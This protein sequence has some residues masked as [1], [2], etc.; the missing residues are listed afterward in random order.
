MAYPSFYN[1]SSGSSAKSRQIPSMAGVPHAQEQAHL[2][3]TVS[4]LSGE[5]RSIH[6]LTALS[7]RVCD[8]AYYTSSGDPD[9]AYAENLFRDFSAA[10]YDA[11]DAIEYVRSYVIPQ[12]RQGGTEA[13]L[14]E[15]VEEG[16]GAWRSATNSLARVVSNIVSQGRTVDEDS[17]LDEMAGRGGRDMKLWAARMWRIRERL[18][19]VLRSMEDQLNRPQYDSGYNSYESI[20]PEPEYYEASSSTYSTQQ[21]Y[22]PPTP[23]PPPV[24]MGYQ[25]PHPSHGYATPEY[26]YGSPTTS[27]PRITIHPANYDNYSYPSPQQSHRRNHSQTSPPPQSQ[28]YGHRVSY[29]GGT[30]MSNGPSSYSR[31]NSPSA[32]GSPTSYHL[33]EINRHGRVLQHY[34]ERQPFTRYS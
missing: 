4:A 24:P 23:S 1:L 30:S 11:R 33:P 29:S 8:S 31:Y 28:H 9:I 7:S 27:T 6:P 26:R 14:I 34:E 19:K 16:R 17:I 10:W 2:L 21:A 12:L 5:P 32:S 3:L 20:Q 18:E 15:S 22:L 13:M 25:P